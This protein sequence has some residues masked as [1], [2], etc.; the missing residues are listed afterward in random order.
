[1]AATYRARI[2]E[3]RRSPPAEDWNGSIALDKL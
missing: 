2:A 1:V 3:L